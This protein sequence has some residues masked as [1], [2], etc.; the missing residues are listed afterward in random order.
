MDG[1]KFGYLK[2]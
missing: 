1:F 2:V